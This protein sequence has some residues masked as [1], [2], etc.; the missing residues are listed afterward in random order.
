MAKPFLFGRYRLE[1]PLGAG[2]SA[3]VWRATDTRTREDVALKRL[4]PLVFAGRAGREWLL[5]EFRALR[6]L[7][8]PHVVRVRDLELTDEDGALIL[9]YVAG[10]SLA[11]RLTEGRSEERRVGKEWRDAVWARGG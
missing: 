8:E 10:P 6:D 5:R 9:D 3:Q 2:G 4:H 7:D 1:E 11:T